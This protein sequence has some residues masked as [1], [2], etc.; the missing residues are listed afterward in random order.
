MILAAHR[1]GDPRNTATAIERAAGFVGWLITPDSPE[2]VAK[3]K[4]LTQRWYERQAK[5]AR[6]TL[7]TEITQPLPALLRRQAE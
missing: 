3:Q 5:L 6:L 1:G 2:T 4:R 7:N